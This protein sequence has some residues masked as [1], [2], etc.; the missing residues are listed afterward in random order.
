[1]LRPLVVLFL[2]ILFAF[3]KSTAFASTKK[4]IGLAALHSPERIAGLNVA[5][6]YTWGIHPIEGAPKDKFV[7]MIWGSRKGRI[8][9]QTETLKA[10]GKIPF[11]LA[12]NEPDN[13]SQAD[14]SVDQVTELWPQISPLAD[15]LSSP[16]P[17][18]LSK[19]WLDEF[20]Q[21]A[22]AKNLKL[23]FIA[24]HLYGPPN[25]EKFLHKVDAVYAKYKLPIWITEFAVADW[26]ARSKPGTNRYS[27]VQVLT[28]MKALL[29]ELEKR[30]YVAR[31]A[32]FGAGKLSLKREQVRT[33]RLF[34]KDGSLTRL[35]D[36]YA[37]FN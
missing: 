12:I 34:E 17:A 30:R 24:I 35:G 4:G 18:N 6:Y 27:E 26:D 37:K 33:S 10:R 19:P 32:W 2:I 23:S 9:R 21:K 7:P 8:D 29:P 11:L 13:K 5:W 3:G 1:M 14:M 31:Y 25:M 20:F 15:Q 36:F 22:K 28:F 16:A